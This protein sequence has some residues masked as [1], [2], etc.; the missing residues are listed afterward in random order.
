MHLDDTVETSC[1]RHMSTLALSQTLGCICIFLMCPAITCSLSGT[2]GDGTEGGARRT[3]ASPAALVPRRHVST[4]M[5]S[6]FIWLVDL[7]SEVLWLSTLLAVCQMS[8]WQR[9]KLRAAAACQSQAFLLLPW[10]HF[11][12]PCLCQGETSS[13]GNPQSPRDDWTLTSRVYVSGRRAV[14]GNVCWVWWGSLL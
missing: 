8:G 4:N 5:S 11:R 6:W 2:T 12:L 3:D 7:M 14:M 9:W 10:Q 1:M 13:V